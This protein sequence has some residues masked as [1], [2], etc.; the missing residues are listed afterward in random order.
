METRE[1]L[2]SSCNV[3]EIHL[4]QQVHNDTL[5]YGERGMYSGVIGLGKYSQFWEQ[6]IAP[7]EPNFLTANY[8][9]MG[10]S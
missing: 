9:I 4:A 3:M 10:Q 5:L 8:S 7:T 2:T 6:Y 1:K